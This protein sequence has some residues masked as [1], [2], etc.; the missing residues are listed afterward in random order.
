MKNI[1]SRRLLLGLAIASLGST[2]SCK[3]YLNVEPVSSVDSQYVFTSVSG[4]SS[5][6]TGAY[7]L[8]SGDFTYGQRLSAYFPYDSDDIQVSGGTTVDQGRRGI[9][10]YILDANN[11]ELNLPWNAL[12]QGVERA[13]VCI[14]NIPQSPLYTG[15]TAAEQ[16]AM[17]S[18]YG[19]ALTLRA[20]Y[21]LEL[22]RNWGDV[23]APFLPASAT[24]DLRLPNADRDATYEHLLADLLLA[25]TLVPWRSQA[26]TTDEHITKGAVKG[27]RARIALYR[28][29]YAL[30]SDGNMRQGSNPQQFYEIARNECSEIIQSGEHSLNGNFYTLFKNVNELKVDNSE[31]MFEAAMAGGSAISDSK[32]GYYT[33]PKID[34][35]SRYGQGNPGLNVL[36]TYFY[37]FDSLDTRR[38][39]TITY[40]SIGSTNLQTPTTLLGLTDGKLRRDWRVP[41]V[42]GQIQYLGFNWALLRYA[43]VLLMFAEAQNELAGPTAAYN[44]LTPVAALE[45]VRRRAYRTSP[46]SIGTTPTD[47]VG[48]FTALVNERY[49]E[50]GGEGIRKYDLIRWNLLGSRIAATRAN[51]LLLKSDTLTKPSLVYWKQV[52]EGMQLTSFRRPKPAT[53]PTGFKTTG[54]QWLRS[55]SVA[56]TTSF[57]SG[58][59]PGKSELLP[60]PQVAIDNNINLRQNPKY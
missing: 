22:I 8:L 34:Q 13:N 54:I 44:G 17:K 27:L 21:M 12:Y 4:T 51:L 58:F 19:Q 57:A 49:L 60:I 45:Q 5:A 48:F 7:D 29:G 41:F 46:T 42:P 16:A 39:V 50:F 15:G 43:D 30:R 31:I 47:K 24:P 56:S 33:G 35:A 14:Q 6:L 1:A 20:Q 52:G 59:Q 40:Y 3:D 32:L 38:D 25:E 36:P 10:R 28:A 2:F 55:I 9:A 18:M 23:P 37:A 26:G 11:T 53:V